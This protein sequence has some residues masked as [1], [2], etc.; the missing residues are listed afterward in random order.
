MSSFQ[1]YFRSQSTKLHKPENRIYV[2]V[3]LIGFI[4]AFWKYGLHSTLR[5]LLIFSSAMIFAGTI[6]NVMNYLVCKIRTQNFVN[7]L[8]VAVVLTHFLL[9]DSFVSRYS[10]SLGTLFGIVLVVFQAIVGRGKG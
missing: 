8:L 3:I 2:L 9:Q 7:Y 1:D 4:A 6:S 10:L 5:F